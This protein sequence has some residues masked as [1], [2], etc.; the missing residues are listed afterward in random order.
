MATGIVTHMQDAYY[1]TPNRGT[2]VDIQTGIKYNFIRPNPT[3][4]PVKKWDVKEN[5][6]VTFT[7]SGT[8]ATGVT[9]LKRHAEGTVYGY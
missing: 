8:E 2:L 5:D 1:K 3:V 7:I 4:F 6:V 9:L